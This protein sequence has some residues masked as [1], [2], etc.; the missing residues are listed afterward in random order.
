MSRRANLRDARHLTQAQ[1]D[2]ACGDDKTQLPER[3]TIKTCPVTA[4]SG[5]PSPPIGSS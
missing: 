1:L 4:P 5:S 3:L 2:H